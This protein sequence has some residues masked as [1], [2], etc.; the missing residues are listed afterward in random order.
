MF[1]FSL[2]YIFVCVCNIYVNYTHAHT[3][4]CYQYYDIEYSFVRLIIIIDKRIGFVKKKKLQ[5][6]IESI[7]SHD[8]TVGE[9]S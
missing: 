2:G 7:N 3:C 4:V 8:P 5:W 6:N 1:C 9:K